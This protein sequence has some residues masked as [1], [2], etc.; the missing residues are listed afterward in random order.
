MAR[1]QPGNEFGTG[2]NQ[3]S[4]RKTGS[5]VSVQFDSV[6]MGAIARRVA[7]MAARADK[8]ILQAHRDIAYE[9]QSAIAIELQNAVRRRGRAQRKKNENERL[10]AA[11]LSPRNRRVNVDGYTVGYLDDIPSVRPYWRGLEVGSTRHV[12]RF[13]RGSFQNAAGQL[14]PPVKGR[15][16]GRDPR[17]LQFRAQ[18]F[19]TFRE[20]VDARM[21]AG[22]PLRAGLERRVAGHP[23]NRALGVRIKHPIVGYHYFERGIR[24]HL[25]AGWARGDQPLSVYAGNLRAA[26]LGE[27]A[28]TL[29][30]RGVAATRRARGVKAGPI[31]PPTPNPRAYSDDPGF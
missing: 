21:A 24:A 2:Q 28:A 14:V 17:F 18:S 29:T 3:F 13:L 16:V 11:I 27:L 5:L 6:Q 4:P 15:G 20:A 19:A 26:G 7:G 8:P 25:A 9:L 30:G 31:G 12:G 10:A 22:E 23:S 1:F